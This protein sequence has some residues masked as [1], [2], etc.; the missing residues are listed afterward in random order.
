MLK[1]G[2]CGQGDSASTKSDMSGPSS[3]ARLPAGR[4]ASEGRRLQMSGI[5]TTRGLAELP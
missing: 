5:P 1:E 2:V 4:R 3:P